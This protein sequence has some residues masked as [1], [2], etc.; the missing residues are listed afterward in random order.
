MSLPVG[1]NPLDLA[2]LETTYQIGRFIQSFVTEDFKD[3]SG[4]PYS[5]YSGHFRVGPNPFYNQ[6]KQG[7]FLEEYYGM[8][9]KIHTPYGNWSIL[10]CGSGD[11]EKVIEAIK[12]P[13][14]LVLIQARKQT[15][16]GEVGPYWAITKWKELKIDMPVLRERLEYIPYDKVKEV[17]KAFA[18]G[19]EGV[20]K[21]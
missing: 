1:N 10:G 6:T 3:G 21:K 14:G 7:L 18:D 16:L 20:S 13:L 5:D 17:W 9:S 12:E 11:W 19:R 2:L 4:K 15:T 8:P